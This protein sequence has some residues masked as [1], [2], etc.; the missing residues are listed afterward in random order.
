MYFYLVL[1]SKTY[2]C[3]FLYYL[4]FYGC[5]SLDSRCVHVAALPGTEVLGGGGGSGVSRTH[6]GSVGAL[7]PLLEVGGF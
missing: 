6:D 4:T 5:G 1:L 2:F 3:V 7:L